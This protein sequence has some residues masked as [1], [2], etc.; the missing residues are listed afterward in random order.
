VTDPIKHQRLLQRLL[1]DEPISISAR[2]TKLDHCEKWSSHPQQRVGQRRE[3]NR[4]QMRPFYVL[5]GLHEVDFNTR[6]GRLRVIRFRRLMN[7][8]RRG[9]TRHFVFDDGRFIV[10]LTSLMTVVY[11][12][13]R[14]GAGRRK[15]GEPGCGESRERNMKLQR[16]VSNFSACPRTTEEGS[17][18]LYEVVS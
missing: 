12:M 10:S 16:P 9:E 15:Q 3:A 7:D 18:R 13:R 17:W 6:L 14:H 2:H 5:I 1:C 4:R 11:L 8:D